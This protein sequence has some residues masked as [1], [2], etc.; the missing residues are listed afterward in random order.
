M[1]GSSGAGKTYFCLKMASLALLEQETAVIYVDTSNYVNHENMN[2][3][4]RVSLQRKF[5]LISPISELYHD[6]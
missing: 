5:S 6:R 4:L 2:Q 3:V 1:C